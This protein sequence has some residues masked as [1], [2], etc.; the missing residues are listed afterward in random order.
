MFMSFG[1]HA[2][3]RMRPGMR[4]W[5]HQAPRQSCVDIDRYSYYKYVDII[6]IIDII[7]VYL[8]QLAQGEDNF[9]GGA[10]LGPDL[11]PSSCI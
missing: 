4:R 1:F 2:W 10:L 7:Y 11:R 6:D 3:I 9:S 5:G 8:L